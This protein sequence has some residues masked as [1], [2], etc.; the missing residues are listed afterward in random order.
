METH[1]PTAPAGLDRKSDKELLRLYAEQR[2]EEAFAQLG[3]RYAGLIY[4][5]CLRELGEQTQA[6]DAAQA[7]LLLLSQKAAELSRYETILGWLYNTSRYT[8]RN[9]HRQRCR[10]Q[11][12]EENAS[13]R[14]SAAPAAPRNEVWERIEPHLHDALD[15]LK[16]LDRDAVLLRYVQEQ[17]LSE[18][19]VSLGL[20][21]NTVRM[22]VSR[23]LEKIRVHLAK[24]GVVLSVGALAVLLE[25]HAVQASPPSV[26]AAIARIAASGAAITSVATSW[27]GTPSPSRYLT[28]L[29]APAKYLTLALATLVATGSIGVYRWNRPH[30]LDVTEQQRQFAALSGMWRGEITYIDDQNGKPYTYPTTAQFSV[31]DDGQTL[32]FAS[33]YTGSSRKDAIIFSR[34]LRTGRFSIKNSGE[35]ISYALWGVGELVQTRDGNIAFQGNNIAGTVQMRLQ[36]VRRG[37]RLVVRQEYRPVTRLFPL[38]PFSRYTLRNR[39]VLQRAR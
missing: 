33:T 26:F 11:T 2:S 22:R 13:M 23:A 21:E 39:Y 14:D 4:T 32:H 37:N 36:F 7:V 34:D 10:R 6:E 12:A 8:C 19:G 30:P 16:P 5:T 17:S 20:S 25:E 27:E 18:I 15:R 29:P 1:R 31:R 35:Q 28:R 38:N 9:L 24:E 3:R